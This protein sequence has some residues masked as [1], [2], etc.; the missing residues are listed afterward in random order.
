MNCKYC[1]TEIEDNATE[2]PCCGTST[3]ENIEVVATAETPAV[4]K[5][6]KQVNVIGIV[7]LLVSIASIFLGMYYCIVPALGVILNIVGLVM[8]KKFRLNGFAI[9]GLVISLIALVCWGIVWMLIYTLVSALQN[10]SCQPTP[11]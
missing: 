3:A 4:P 5:H 1:G 11:A 7:G 6:K 8:W 2:C 9:A 10:I